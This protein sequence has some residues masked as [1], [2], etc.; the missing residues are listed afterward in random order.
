M[1][2]LTTMSEKLH[3]ILRGDYRGKPIGLDNI[4]A[5]L[6]K[7]FT[8]FVFNFIEGDNE[9][10][11]ADAVLSIQEGS[12]QMVLDKNE[13]V[14]SVFTDYEN[15]L[16][17][18]QINKSR[19]RS[20][21]KFQNKIAKKDNIELVFTDEDKEFLVSGSTKLNKQQSFSVDHS[22]ILNGEI[23]VMGGENPKIRL[24]TNDGEIYS[25]NATKD[26]IVGLKENLLYT[27]QSLKVNQ[28]LDGL[29]LRVKESNLVEFV[30]PFDFDPEKLRELQKEVHEQWK[31]VP[32][33]T[34]WVERERGN[35]Q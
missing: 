10:D 12:A 23:L 21:I 27:S 4:P 5:D 30:E 24:K 19:L 25:I 3:F 11:L 18:K 16:E 2:R 1:E 22:L 32:D 6:Y 9:V 7:G 8:D 13:K 20:T 15:M 35:I 31:D 34:E 26:Q 33:I 29:T 28:K 17:G 14:A